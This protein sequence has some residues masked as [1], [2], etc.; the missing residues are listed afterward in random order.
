MEYQRKPLRINVYLRDDALREKLE[1][2]AQEAGMSLSCTIRKTLKEAL[3][4]KE[5]KHVQARRVRQAR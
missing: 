1:E 3:Y 4:G 2:I 5:N